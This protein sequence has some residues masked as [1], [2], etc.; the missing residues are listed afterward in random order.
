MGY[1]EFKMYEAVVHVA[2]ILGDVAHGPL[3]PDVARSAMDFIT[4]FLTGGVALPTLT[5]EVALQEF[6][7]H[8]ITAAC[9][10]IVSLNVPF[11]DSRLYKIERGTL[12]IMALEGLVEYSR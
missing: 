10:I 9:A 1:D 5:E 6:G 2:S 8:A 3:V 12:Y 7:S 11:H 4:N